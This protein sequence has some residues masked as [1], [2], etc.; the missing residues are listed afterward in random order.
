MGGTCGGV[1]FAVQEVGGVVAEE[2]GLLQLHAGEVA[3]LDD[4]IAVFHYVVL[5]R[6]GPHA[7]GCGAHISAPPHSWLDWCANNCEAEARRCVLKVQVC[8]P[9][10]LLDC[11][12]HA[13]WLC[14][15]LDYVL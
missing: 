15:V 14:S 2:E 1:N 6:H 4:T 10:T 13:Q 12:M 7:C 5:H 9:T 11:Y 8:K 3:C